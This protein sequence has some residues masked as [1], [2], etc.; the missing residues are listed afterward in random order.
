[1]LDI[2]ACMCER[3]W[4]Q[5]LI[6]SFT[7][8]TILYHSVYFYTIQWSRSMHSYCVALTGNLNLTYTV[9]KFLKNLILPKFRVFIWLL[10]CMIYETSPD[11][12]LTS[13]ASGNILKNESVS[14]HF[15]FLWYELPVET[16]WELKNSYYCT[17]SMYIHI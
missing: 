8:P 4:L 11:T 9:L 3:Q 14:V 15:N 10:D 13:S 12:S 7:I 6:I 17:Y 2:G 16:S 5:Y 1:M